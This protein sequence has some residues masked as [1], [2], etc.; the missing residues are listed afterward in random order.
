MEYLVF[1]DSHGHSSS[2]QSILAAHPGAKGVFFCG[3]G[4]RDLIGL[5][6]AFPGVPVYAVR[7]NC[8]F[9]A[10]AD[11]VPTE[12]LLCFEGV[13]ILLLHGHLYG[14]KSGLGV[15]LSHA[16][17]AG[18]DIL[19]YGHTHSPAEKTEQVGEKYITLANPGS[20]GRAPDGKIHYG[21]L[22]LQ[23]GQYL[24]SLAEREERM[25]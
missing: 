8:D 6:A 24:F 17:E 20:I 21:V 15:A 4:L 13:R 12:R 19:L 10:A 5:E 14:V 11:G 7:G 25:W 16:A 23:N 9:G 18:A 2:M 22:T 1:S 3:D